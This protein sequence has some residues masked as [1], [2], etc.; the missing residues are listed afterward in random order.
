MKTS[1]NILLVL[2]VLVPLPTFACEGCKMAGTKGLTEPQTVMAGMAFSWSVLF[3]LTAVFLLLGVFAW[4][5][6]SACLQAEAAHHGE[7]T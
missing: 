2:S 5:M 6:R 1:L 7:K 3:M 4:L